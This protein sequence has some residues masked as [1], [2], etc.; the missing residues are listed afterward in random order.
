MTDVMRLH[1]SD[2]VVVALSD[3][4][5]GAE[6]PDLPHPL[7]DP[8]P[9]G[10]KAAIARIEAGAP[11]LRYGQIIGAALE[12]ISAGNHVHTHNLGMGEHTRDY[13][14]SSE[15]S[16][17]PPVDGEAWFDGYIRAD[18]RVGTR[19]YL[20]VLTSVN[21]SGSVARFIAE[22]AVAEGLLTAFPNVDG[23]VPVVHGTGCGMSG[24]HEGYDTLF[25]T[26]KGYARH[27][28]F[29]GILLV[30]LGCEVMQIPDLIGAGRMRGGRQF[31]LH[32]HPADGRDTADRCLRSGDPA[33]HGGE[34]ERGQACARAG[35]GSR[36]GA[37]VRRIGRLF[38]HH[39]QSR[40]RAR[41]GPRRRP[42]R[43]DNSRG[44][45]GGLRRG[46]PA[47]TAG[48]FR[49]GRA[50]AGGPYRVVGGLH[51]AQRRRDEQQPEPGQQAGRTDNHSGENPW[52]PSR[53]A[54]RRR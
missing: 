45:D 15:A 47:D 11:V 5:R 28:N 23:I 19:N 44:D 22:A 33:R 26:L 2:N 12:P 9:R 46:A 18:G 27:P 49:G 7:L 30:G 37:A 31:S 54:G 32:D 1:S 10:H 29:A 13:A 51:V 3:L 52:V 14:F 43:N 16:P 38:G 50:K 6:H 42:R 39:R 34:G 21:C 48:G 8:V 53:R 35:V 41:L 25:R 24:R 36:R 40:A 17:L 4:P 20:G